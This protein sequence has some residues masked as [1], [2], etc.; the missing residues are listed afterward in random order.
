MIKGYELK[1]NVS[2]SLRTHLNE[3]IPEIINL[4]RASLQKLEDKQRKLRTATTAVQTADGESIRIMEMK[5]K[6]S[7]L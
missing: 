1:E 5:R 2:K 7:S 4:V 6:I 3:K